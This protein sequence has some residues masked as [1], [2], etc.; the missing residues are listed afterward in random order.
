MNNEWKFQT[1]AANQQG[2]FLNEITNSSIFT[3]RAKCKPVGK[4][5]GRIEIQPR[6]KS[7]IL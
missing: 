5:K 4:N 1:P 2:E 3:R 6:V 7:N